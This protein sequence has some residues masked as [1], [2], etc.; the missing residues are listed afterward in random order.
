[1][2]YFK[3]KIHIKNFKSNDEKLQSYLEKNIEGDVNEYENFKKNLGTSDVKFLARI[4][5]PLMEQANLGNICDKIVEV[6][7]K[8]GIEPNNLTIAIDNRYFK[9]TLSKNELNVLHDFEN[10]FKQKGV[11]F[12]IFDYSDVYSYKKVK[13]ADEDMKSVANKLRASN[14]SPIEKLMDV[15]AIETEWPYKLEN[16]DESTAQS[17]SVYGILNSDK[18]VCAGYANFLKAVVDEIDDPGLKVFQNSCVVFVPNL[19]EKDKKYSLHLNLIAY[20]KDEKYGI[21]G[22]FMM[23]PTQDSK[24]DKNGKIVS[25]NFNFMLTG[26]GDLKFLQHFRYLNQLDIYNSVQARIDN[27]FD[28]YSNGHTKTNLQAKKTKPNL[29]SEN[30]A[31]KYSSVS[32]SSIV[33]LLPYNRGPKAEETLLN[34]LT[35]SKNLMS[36]K[37]KTLA[38]ERYFDVMKFSNHSVDKIFKSIC[39]DYDKHPEKYLTKEMVFEFLRTHSNEHLINPKFSEASSRKFLLKQEGLKAMAAEKYFSCHKVSDKDFDK[40]FEDFCKNYD[41]YPE[42]YV[43]GNMI[44]QFMKKNAMGYTNQITLEVILK[45]YANVLKFECPQM[46]KDQVSLQVY[47]KYLNVAKGAKKYYKKNA[48][49]PGRDCNDDVLEKCD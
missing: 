14:L 9:K 42:K 47:K 4:D 45:A 24:V 37:L 8:N 19:D 17:R 22:F 32:D 3:S 10:N 44:M 2:R 15:Y 21:D 20:I 49:V 34:F 38:I 27:I 39:E 30:M 48:D 36:E 13:K 35:D 7:K 16:E 1:M 12:G 29:I 25:K 43:D 11:E 41:I 31:P 28:Y 6:C 46:T 26:F 23:D 5:R 40:K 33:L 18:V